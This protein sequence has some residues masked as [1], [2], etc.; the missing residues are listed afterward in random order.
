MKSILFLFTVCV[1]VAYTARSEKAIVFSGGG[2][3]LQRRNISFEPYLVNLGWK[4]MGKTFGMISSGNSQATGFSVEMPI[5][6]V[7]FKG[8][9][10]VRAEE[11]GSLAARWTVVPSSD[12]ELEECSILA[13]LPVNTY[14]GG[15]VFVD[16]QCMVFPLE[17]GSDRIVFAGKASVLEL[18]DA[19]GAFTVKLNLPTERSMLIQDSRTYNCPWFELRMKMP[20]RHFRG[21][22][23]VLD[24][25]IALPS[26]ESF[27]TVR[28]SQCEV[29][30]SPC[31][32]PVRKASE[33]LPGS[34]VDFTA[35]R[36]NGGV[37]AGKYGY[38]VAKD[39]HFEFE[40]LQGIKQR[41][42]GVNLCYKACFPE[43]GEAEKLATMLAAYGYNSVRLHH[44]DDGGLVGED[45]TTPLEVRLRQLDTLID[46]CV[47]HGL[48]LTMDLLC[49]R[50]V[51]NAI[52]GIDESGFVED[53]K[54][55]VFFHEGVF[56]NQVRYVKSL[57]NHRNAYTGR[58]YAE[59]PALSLISLVNE[60][61][62]V[63]R[64]TPVVGTQAYRMT[65]PV[66]K[67]WIAEQQSRGEFADVSGEYP[68]NTTQKGS[69]PLAQALQKFC[70]WREDLFAARM[71]RLLRDELGCKALL[72]SLNAGIPPS[73]YDE[74]RKKN[75]D[76]CDTHYYWD[77]P[78]FLGIKWWLPSLSGHSGANPVCT[79]DFGRRVKGDRFYG[80]PQTVTELNFCPPNRYRSMY[81]LVTG[82]NAAHD[83][84]GGAWRFCW[85]C[86]KGGVGTSSQQTVGWFAV[87][88]DV[89]ALAAER[90]VASL[91]LRGDMPVGNGSYGTG[92]GI[93]INR[94]T[95]T[96]TV[97]TALTAGGF[98]EFGH[99]D[100]STLVADFGNQSGCIWA[101]SLTES[102]IKDSRRILVTHL[103]D[104]V[105]SGT[106]F[107]DGRRTII[108]KWGQTPHL[109]RSG[110]I[111]VALRTSLENLS[112]Y[113]LD[114]RG[115]RRG[116]IPS[117]YSDGWL[118]FTADIS[119]FQDDA[120]FLYEIAH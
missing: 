93:K 97:D 82:A 50:K 79:P 29:K 33:I 90:A 1:C 115:A 52:V 21:I 14:A 80:Q 88:G 19:G 22:T 38:L 27:E 114:S 42:Y 31:W 92:E 24:L 62:L 68:A 73:A 85:G 55:A 51:P 20:Q 17:E 63:D 32:R 3:N 45:G 36:G 4:G 95:G 23:N 2:L 16:G 44:F 15:K 53:I 61:M 103:T 75:F 58:R 94:F 117:S 99:L 8:T 57:L 110:R 6:G 34:A 9:V 74:M 60:G 96:V 13:K 89:I 12:L 116:R 91:F 43:P 111:D 28:A 59:E 49:S 69:S 120:T 35:I 107:R 101:T 104:G 70:A 7:R 26:G 46:A 119:M 77:H 87:A 47:R 108:E 48:Y 78:R 118:K 40:H 102:S 76:Y 105:D 86:E 30:A 10:G 98:R 41:F 56:S 25:A 66:W 100:T 18:F 37:P 106:V 113:A 72:T 5:S 112:V 64:K 39:G 84:W 81:G 71:R 54:W 11:E 67:A 109:L 65:A 83:D